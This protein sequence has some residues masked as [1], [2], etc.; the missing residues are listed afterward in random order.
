MDEN[1]ELILEVLQELKKQVKCPKNEKYNSLKCVQA[2]TIR[3]IENMLRIFYP[4][5]QKDQSLKFEQYHINYDLCH[6]YNK[7]LN[8]QLEADNLRMIIARYKNDFMDFCRFSWL[9]VEPIINVI[10][11]TNWDYRSSLF[12]NA[13]DIVYENIY[14]EKGKNQFG[15]AIKKK[16]TEKIWMQQKIELCLTI[17]SNNSD[18]IYHNKEKDETKKYLLLLSLYQLRNISSHREEGLTIINRI[19]NINYNIVR[20]KVYELYEQKQYQAIKKTV[21]WF[22]SRC[23]QWIPPEGRK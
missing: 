2:K 9:Q 4:D 22:I 13:C 6:N 1:V 21:Y 18:D 20:N 19:E 7:L 10:I 17:I 3:E 8:Q 23:N 12:K 11:Q 15:N 14:H 16:N 5:D